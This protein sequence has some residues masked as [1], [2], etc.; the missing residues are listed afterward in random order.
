MCPSFFTFGGINYA[1]Y[2]SLCLVFLQ[3]IY[4]THPCVKELLEKGV[5]RVARSLLPG[6][7]NP[8]DLTI[9]QTFMKHAKSKGDGTSV[10]II[11]IRRNPKAYQHWVLTRYHRSLYLN[12]TYRMADLTPD[13][14]TNNQHKDTRASQIVRSEKAVQDALKATDGFINPFEIERKENLFCLASGAAVKP[15][16]N[17]MFLVQKK[18]EKLNMKHLWSPELLTKCFSSMPQ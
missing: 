4:Q 18:L 11:G 6:C 1:G 9:E 7:R 2:L 5:P 15:L 13:E 17:K 8:V 3:N 14:H 16:L 12:A 10:G